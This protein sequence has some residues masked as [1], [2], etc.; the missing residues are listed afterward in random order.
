MS[1]ND[2]VKFLT[3]QAVK[4]MDEPKE[5]RLTR[6]EVRRAERQPLSSQAFG[7]IPLGISLYWRKR[8]KK[9]QQRK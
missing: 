6:K 8:T 7:I 5:E 2:Y 1:L 9:K 4:R 3:E